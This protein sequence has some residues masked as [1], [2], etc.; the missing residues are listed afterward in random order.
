MS[1]KHQNNESLPIVLM[2]SLTIEGED[3]LGKKPFWIIV[4]V[5][6]HTQR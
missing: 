1:S 5:P 2:F 6:V 3:S 4:A